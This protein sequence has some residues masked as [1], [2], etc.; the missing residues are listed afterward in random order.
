MKKSVSVFLLSLVLSFSAR[1]ADFETDHWSEGLHLLAGGGLNTAVYSSDD[2]HVDGGLGVNLKTDLLY[3]FHPEWA[4]EWSANVK[5]HRM[6]DDFLLWDTLL[7]VG[8]RTQLPKFYEEM[9][10]T[11]YARF[12]VGRAPTVLFLNGKTPKGVSDPSTSRIHFDGP[13]AGLGF[14]VFKKNAQGKVWFTEIAATAQA[15]ESEE[16]VMMDGEVP[17]VL[18]RNQVTNNARIYSIAVTFGI[19]AF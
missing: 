4:V 13:V 7:T 6:E 2:D 16:D 1:A 8:L 17:L 9:P 12:F 11:P 3:V 10:G 15:L 18:S 19:L 14:G 5:F